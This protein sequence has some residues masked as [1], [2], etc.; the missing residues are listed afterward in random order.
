MC[1]VMQLFDIAANLGS[2]L[3]FS[4]IIAVDI[5]IADNSHNATQTVSRVNVCAGLLETFD[6]LTFG[7]EP[8]TYSAACKRAVGR[9][10]RQKRDHKRTRCTKDRAT[11]EQLDLSDDGF[12]S[13]TSFG[14]VWAFRSRPI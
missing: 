2:Q 8:V 7:R 10:N 14:K 5:E 4:P 9:R 6:F 1:S 12:W 11:F 13:R 3:Y